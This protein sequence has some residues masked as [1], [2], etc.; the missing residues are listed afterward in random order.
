MMKYNYKFTV[1]EEKKVRVIVHTDC[2]NEAD[3]QFALAHHLLTPKFI[4][5]GII[6]AHFESKP[7]EGMGL[8]MQKSYDEIKRVLKLMN[9]ESDYSVYKGAAHPLDCHE[10]TELEANK[11]SDKAM[12]A[13]PKPIRSEGAEFIIKEAMREDAKPL[14]IACLGGLTDIA[15]AYL[16]EPEIAKRMTVIWI[17][18]SVYPRGGFE[19]NL[20]QDI[21]A[22]N[23]LFGSSIP[24]W[25]IPK[26]V[27]KMLKV[28]LAELQLRVQP[29]G[30]IGDYLFNQIVQ[31]NDDYGAQLDWPHGEGWCLGDQPTI[32]VLLEFHEH[33]YSWIPAPLFSRDMY[34]VHEQNNR[35]IRVYHSVD[36]RLTMEDFYCKLQIN[37][38]IKNM[39]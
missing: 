33:D 23:V 3:D 1:P 5:K 30:A 36:S 25:Q 29:H 11:F 26:N 20:L 12:I 39:F 28:S 35:P 24:L 27:Y 22:A 13:S 14:Y 15:S 7:E 10:N 37:Y 8:S 34:Y 6:A 32:S 19:F 18:G 21:P 2:K 17:G 16:M 38:G 4:V 9:L 31:Y